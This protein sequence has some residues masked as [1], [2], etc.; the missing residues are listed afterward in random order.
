M[1]KIIKKVLDRSERLLTKMDTIKDTVF[2]NKAH[3]DFNEP[4]AANTK[5]GVLSE[6]DAYFFVVLSASK[7]TFLIDLKRDFENWEYSAFSLVEIIQSLIEDG[8][9]LLSERTSDSFRNF[10]LVDSLRLLSAWSEFESW[11]TVIYLTAQGDDRWESED[12]GIS[13]QRAQFLINT[14][15]VSPAPFQ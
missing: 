4:I 3:D 15:K 8:T 13:D 9:I 1:K 5:L 10:S 14:N 6:A 11:N 2:Q 7:E 12:W